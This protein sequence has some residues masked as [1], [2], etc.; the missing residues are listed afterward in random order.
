MLARAIPGCIV[1][2]CEQRA[3]AAALA[4]KRFGATVLLLDDGRIQLEVGATTD[5]TIQTRVVDGGELG[6]RKGINAPGVALQVEGLTS[7]DLEDLR[8]GASVG[9]DLIALSFVQSANDVER[10]RT[11]LRDAGA[12]GIPLVAKLERPQAIERLDEVIRVSDAV[13]VARGD[14]GVEM[15]PEDVPA[16]QKRIIAACRKSGKPV[17]VATQML[18]SMITSPSPT[19][20][21][22]SD[23]AT[24]VYDGADAVMLSAETAVGD[25]PVEA[26]GMMDRIL[27]KVERDPLYRSYLDAFHAEAEH[28]APDA[29]FVD[30]KFWLDLPSGTGRSVISGGERWEDNW[31]YAPDESLDNESLIAEAYQGIRPAPGY[32]ACP[33]HTE[34][35]TLFRLLEAE[36]VRR[37]ESVE[38]TPPLQRGDPAR[39]HDVRRDRG[40]SHRARQSPQRRSYGARLAILRVMYEN[41]IDAFVHPEVTVHDRGHAEGAAGGRCR[42]RLTGPDSCASR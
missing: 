32:P 5:R 2:V 18:E 30:R 36:R 37:D 26:V 23:V 15:P 7:R 21:E 27:T 39:V 22:A 34:K 35:A 25:Y 20:A 40:R 11:A 13:M 42:L 33:D 4:T 6:E 31:G 14:L 3:V 41:G 38:Q 28:T 29:I 17:V 10:A 16:I 1:L 24:A 12:P 19:R 9:V 8:F